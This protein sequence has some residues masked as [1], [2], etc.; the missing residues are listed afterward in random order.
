MD[1]VVVNM[2]EKVFL[3]WDREFFEN[4]FRNG[5]VELYGR[6]ISNFERKFCIYFYSVYISLYFYEK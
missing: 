3:S 5:R 4:L 1:R 2:G 6:L